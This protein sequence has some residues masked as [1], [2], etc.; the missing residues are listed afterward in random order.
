[1]K[2]MKRE[3][4]SVLIGIVIAVGLA[5][6][7]CASMASAQTLVNGNF[8]GGNTNGVGTGWTS[9]LQAGATGAFAVKNTGVLPEGL[10]YQQVQVTTAN[11]Y[12]GVYQVV[13]G[14]TPCTT[15]TV[16][17]VHR[18]NSTSATSTI[19]VDPAGGTSRASATPLC[20]GTT[21][22]DWVPFSG[23]VT[24]TSTTFTIY[25]DLV[26]TTASKA[27]AYDA[28]T[29]TA[30]SAPAAPTGAA[31]NPTTVCGG[32]ASTLTASVAAGCTIDWYAGSCCGTLVGSGTTLVV[33][34]TS[35]TTYY[36]R[37]RNTTT[38][39][40]SSGCGTPVTVTATASPAA[41]TSPAAN[42]SSISVGAS[43]TLTASV[44][45]GCVVDWYSGSCG[46]TLVGTGT[47]LVVTPSVTTTYYPRARNL[48]GGCSSASCGSSV[49]VTVGI[50]P[51][52][53]HRV[54]YHEGG[55]HD[56]L[57]WETALN[58]ISEAV[59]ASVSGNEV[60]VAAGTY[61]ENIVLPSGVALYGGFAGTETT[62]TQRNWMTNVSTIDADWAAPV[63]EVARSADSS[64]RIDGFTLTHGRAVDGGG[65][66]CNQFANPVITNNVITSCQADYD[67]GGVFCNLGSTATITC[68]K[69][70]NCG[71]VTAG[72]GVRS[73]TGAVI[74]ANN[75]IVGNAA[76]RGGGVCCGD[77]STASHEY[78]VNNTIVSNTGAD[79]GGGIHIAAMSSATIANN[80]VAYN[81]RGISVETGTG[82]Q[83]LTKNCFYGN[84]GGNY[85]GISQGGT[86]ILSDPQLASV[87]YG[88]FHIQ[89]SSPC[90]NAGANGSVI[91]GYNDVDNQTRIQNT[92]VDIGADESDG[93]TYT[94]TATI[95]RV[96][97]SGSDSN[98]GSSWASAK[99]SIQ[100]AIDAVSAAGGGE[101]WV[102]AGTYQERVTL[103][104][105]VYVY[106]G[107][108]G[109]ETD[110]TQRNWTSNVTIIDGQ[111]G[112]TC[113]TSILQGYRVSAI[114]GFKIQNGRSYRGAGVLVDLASPMVMNNT[115]TNNVSLGSGG[116][117]SLSD[118]CALVR[119]NQITNNTALTYGAGI[120][121][122]L[123]SAE[124]SRNNI[125]G[126]TASI[127]G[128]GVFTSTGDN[129]VLVNNRI[130]RNSGDTSKGPSWGSAVSGDS[131]GNATLNCNTISDNTSATGSIYAGVY[132]N[133]KMYSNIVYG[134]SSGITKDT[135]ATVSQTASYTSD[136]LF[137]NRTGGNYQ[138]SSSSAC[139][140][141]ADEATAPADDYLGYTRND[142]DIGCYEYGAG[143]PETPVAPVSA[144]ATPSTICSGAAST[145]VATGGS[146][147]TLRWMTG[148]CGG[149]TVGTGNNLV[150]YPSATT[151]YYVRWETSAGNSTC[152]TTTVT[153]SGTA[154]TATVGGPQ[155]IEVG[156]TTTA[157]GG[158]TPTPPA[159]GAWSIVSG[160]TGTF[161]S[162]TDPNAT[163]T[164]TGGD[165]PIV[166][167]WSVT[168]SPCAPATADV[169]VMIGQHCLT[170]GDFD[171]AF[172]GGVAD[173]WTKQTPESGTW[174][175]ETSIKHS[176]TSSQKIVDASGSPSYTSWIY[177]TVTVQ[178][179]RVYV[180][181][182]WIYRL[183]SAVA[184]IGIDPD[185][186]T[187]FV[188]SD[189]APTSNTWTYRMH[190]P[191]T[192]GSSGQVTIGLAAGYQTNSGTIYYDDV[193]LEPQ[194][195]QTAGGTATIT[196]GGSATLTASG[197]FGGSSSEMCWYTGANGTGTKVGTGTSILVFPT[198]TT[199]YYPRWETS[200]ACAISQDGPP[201]T[202]TVTAPV[203][204]P[205]LTSITPSTGANNAATSITNLAGTGFLAGASVKLRRAGQADITA[206]GVTVVDSTKITCSLNLTGKKTGL[207]DV[208]VT[209]TDSQYATLAGSFGV[210]LPITAPTVGASIASLLDQAASNAAANRRF[211]AWGRVQVIDANTFWLDDGS[212]TRIK[213]FAP[214]YVG[215]T[216]G[217]YASAIGTID[218]SVTPPVLVSASD[219]LREY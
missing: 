65:V 32:A 18:T 48:T 172:T 23:T 95:K 139:I 83:S 200:G 79:S 126:N 109:T 14:C 72:G 85:S 19:L 162:A 202:V 46:G 29:V 37:A 57:T 76:R 161:S 176:G 133:M 124:I 6:M 96:A 38:G 188:A 185:G 163:F 16:S 2:K 148:S 208:I 118:S 151:T 91:A 87:S 62:R 41:P 68:N 35:T 4:I 135:N 187:N 191:F 204:A 58:T 92:T 44:T 130:V 66:Y 106:G 174:A 183:N 170:N 39:C 206:T 11:M 103:R 55:I 143:A 166:L 26:V 100:A 101:V 98:N 201:V 138:L 144:S 171:G 25:C 42:P 215:L 59:G 131:Y 82:S 123:T 164:H 7:L 9:Y 119:V 12:G 150:V 40:G 22:T 203:P 153:V 28:I 49:T 132:G 216:T 198:S 189:G 5:V 47:S 117:I 36:P 214:G 60:W 136:P 165:G 197:G 114:D 190:D 94:V 99:R 75:F 61:N 169:V 45:A 156:G 63:I 84:V 218:L 129:V 155:T 184:H 127:N 134:N 177:Q 21:S 30:C 120:F 128:S 80:I 149:A 56:G 111:A 17:G 51:S 69:I 97:T 195:P 73:T 86:D 15:Y 88:N 10:Q 104:D 158:N 53:V 78:I 105:G 31:A 89:N 3:R 116:G 93:T 209:N 77:T 211:C 67:G 175:Q 140:N 110:K 159:T 157:L 212:A 207:W 219:K 193:A 90:K 108:A 1:M 74:I 217:D 141:A 81:A 199:T 27:S 154:P 107:F 194:A 52:P 173:G 34:P 182:M 213:V 178:P 102:K 113:V 8:E 147:T 137:V 112:G 71:A 145:L 122:Q 43:S 64:T 121:S 180:P 50:P 125:E 142:P 146:G 160:G 196:A 54:K 115:I 24:P 181:T 186:G 205:T 192:S 179:N 13:T 167:R 70:I 168:L 33:N 210:T 20:A 152:V